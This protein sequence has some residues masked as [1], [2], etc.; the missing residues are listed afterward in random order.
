MFY[1]KTPLS[2]DSVITT[3]ITD[4]NVFTRCPDCG[5][6]LH[7]DLN[8]MIEDGEINLEYTTV[9]CEDCYDKRFKKVFR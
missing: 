7:I 8:D 5:K 6:E 9:C 1:V 4:D 2:E 3:N